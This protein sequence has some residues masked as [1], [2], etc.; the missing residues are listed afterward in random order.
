MESM[1][2]IMKKGMETVMVTGANGFLGLALC[3]RLVEC[4]KNVIAVVRKNKNDDIFRELLTKDNF[5]LI[6][7]KMKEYENLQEKI[8]VQEIDICFHLA[9]EGT[10]GELRSNYQIQ[11][12][13]YLYSCDLLLAC[14]KLNCKKFIFASSIMEFEIKEAVALGLPIAQNS[15]YSMCKSITSDMLKL[16]AAI[17][18]I[19]Y[20]K[21]IISNIYGPGEY[22][23]RLINT[24]LRKMINGK[25]CSYTEGSQMYDFIYITDAVEAFIK[26]TFEGKDDESY[27]IGSLQ[28][29]PLKEFLLEMQQIAC[30]NHSIGLGEVVFQGVSLDYE[31]FDV[32]KL[33]RDTGFYPKI[34]FGEG[35]K[36][37]IEWI[38]EIDNGTNSL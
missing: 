8:K 18:N 5:Q 32:Q 15:I 9:W 14:K 6:Y 17:H 19:S 10:S 30:P 36:K 37:T 28:P 25:H 4:K 7:C 26:A 24:S 3:R 38:K 35:I 2:V 33:K 11:N 22:S 29:K 34:E 12:E 1:E 16:M 20:T 21:L 23:E 13:N 27:Y 31:E